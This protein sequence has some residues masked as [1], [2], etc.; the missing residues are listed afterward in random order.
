[1]QILNDLQDQILKLERKSLNDLQITLTRFGITNEDSDTLQQSIQQI[2]DLF[3]LVVVGEF[4]S[5]KSSFINALLGEKLLK[6]GVTPTTTEINILRFDQKSE[7]TLI[8]PNF[9]LIT[10]PVELL[11]EISIV[12]TP[13]TNAIIREHEE[14]TT[15]FIPQS[16]LVLFVT[17]SDRPFT[18]SE[19][20]F[21]E[22]IRNWGKKLVVVINKIDIL[23]S[24]DEIEQIC[25]FV[26][27]N[28]FSLLGIHPDIFPISSRS[29]L[30]A[31]N[32]HPELWSVSRF[33]ALEKHIHQ[34]LD[35]KGR[36][37]LKFLNPLGVGLHLSD[38]YLNVINERLLLLDDDLSALKNVED[39]LSIFREDILKDFDYRLSDIVNILF[40]MEQ[41]AQVYFEETMRLA[42][43]ADLMNKKR[44][45]QEFEQK[46]IANV[47][48]QI[49][50]KVNELID[51][52]VDRNFQQWEAVMTHLAERRRQHQKHII[53]DPGTASFNYD[54][55]R[56]IE[57]VSREAGKVIESYDKTH[58]AQSIA[59]SAQ[60]AVAATAAME[61]SAI[62][63]G[64]VITTIA[65][66]MAADVTGVL[67]ASMVAVLGL[68]V[69]PAKRRKANQEMH[70]KI[71]LMRENLV[72]SLQ[73][74]FTQEIDRSIDHIHNAV[75]PYSRFVRTEQ[76]KLET[77]QND[78]NG[79][80]QELS[81]LKEEVQ[82]F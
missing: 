65:T 70:D 68:F 81:R 56:L 60:S 14:I 66:T 6:A 31:K 80:I 34:T 72:G 28:V 75:S 46:V 7:N 17:S 54:R 30:S 40:E 20:S 53:G 9:H 38:R 29:A 27:D 82:N 47:P 74:Q 58:E 26:E 43:I 67:I 76:G 18:E 19:R 48:Q 50:Q 4:N 44:I 37:Q 41:R 24:E 57:A 77:S 15:R 59:D 36:I 49:D 11:Q 78:L 69:I 1:M 3:L 71:T 51:W 39:Q 8:N 35:E 23:E 32:G 42:R 55:E 13:G 79:I 33:E 5:G 2:D 12:D 22:K 52:M 21:L 64:A 25:D 73:Q 16:D 45:Q 62:G 10:A 63:L 61:I